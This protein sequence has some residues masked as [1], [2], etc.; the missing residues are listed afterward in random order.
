MSG[1]GEVPPL[2]ASQVQRKV[3]Q[4]EAF[5]NDVL[6]EDLKRAQKRK[7]ELQQEIHEYEQLELNCKQVLEVRRQRVE[8]GGAAPK[9]GDRD[10]TLPAVAHRLCCAGRMPA[11][12]APGGPGR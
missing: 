6:K 1:A 5:V 8:G 4:Y 3:R 10:A 11:A 12:D 2:P 9:R 7:A